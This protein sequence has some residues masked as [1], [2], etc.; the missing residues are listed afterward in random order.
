MGE[1]AH[2]HQQA[3]RLE[4]ERWV[5]SERAR[6]MRDMHDGLGGHLV[7]MLASVEAGRSDPQSVALGVREALDELRLSLD[8]LDPDFGGLDAAMAALRERLTPRLTAAGIRVDW[9]PVELP[10]FDLEPAQVL[11]LVR[12]VQ[13]AVTNVLKHARARSVTV[14]VGARPLVGRRLA[15]DV[16]VRDD[17]VGLPPGPDLEATQGRGLQSMRRRAE[18]LGARLTLDST[19]QGTSIRVELV[20]ERRRGP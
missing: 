19:D 8:S 10:A 4:R 1:V 3:L 13:E 7:S 2:Y 6:L 20:L 12:I 5:A 16:A 18:M 15:L 11:G 17:G 14:L 9:P